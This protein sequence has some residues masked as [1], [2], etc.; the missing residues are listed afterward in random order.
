MEGTKRLSGPFGCQGFPQR[1]KLGQQ[2][3]LPGILTLEM[4]ADCLHPL[5]FR[6]CDAD[7][8]CEGTRSSPSRRRG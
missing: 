8:R 3:L 5:A 2:G 6:R 7:L 1:T 4:R